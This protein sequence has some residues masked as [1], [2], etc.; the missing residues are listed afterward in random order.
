M[1]DAAPAPAPV[2]APV[3]APAAPATIT[4]DDF[5]KVELKVG[6][7]LECGDHANANKLLVLKVDLGNGD[8]RQIVSGIKQWYQPADLVGKNV[9]VVANLNPVVLRGVESRGMILAATSGT[10]VIVLTPSKD[11]A[12]GSKV[13]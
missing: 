6:K 2:P 12:P 1:A 5:K 8:I 13:S 4:I 9:I 10:E 11:A 7:V 3:P